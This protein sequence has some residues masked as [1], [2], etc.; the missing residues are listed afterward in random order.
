MCQSPLDQ[1]HVVLYRNNSRLLYC[2]S[3]S[4]TQFYPLKN[5]LNVMHDEKGNTLALDD[6]HGTTIG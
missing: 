5:V 2:M 6:D 1:E 3:M 4:L